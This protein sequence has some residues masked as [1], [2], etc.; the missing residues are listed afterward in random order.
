MTDG[1]LLRQ[2]VQRSIRWKRILE[3]LQET[4]VAVLGRS[5]EMIAWVPGDTLGTWSWYGYYW[6]PERFWF[7]YGYHGDT[8]QPMV[9][10][11]LRSRHT[12]SW[13]QLRAQLPGI[14]NASVGGDFAYLWSDLG[15]REPEEQ[16]RWFHDRSMELHEYSLLER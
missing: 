1:E 7:G 11:D 13:L 8:W 15:D 4:H 16:G 14:W 10:A 9:S 6:D 5:P 3:R 2:L 12:H